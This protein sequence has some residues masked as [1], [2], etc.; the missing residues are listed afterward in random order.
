VREFLA[1]VLSADGQ[2]RIAGTGWE[3]VLAGIPGP[4][5]PAGAGEVWP[6]WTVLF[7]RQNE[8]L[9]QYQAIFGT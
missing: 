8:L 3:P 4:A 5:R 6:Q 2:R 1:Y 7:G 9:R